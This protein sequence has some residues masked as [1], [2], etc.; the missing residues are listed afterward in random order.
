MN[1]GKTRMGV[2]LVLEQRCFCVNNSDFDFVSISLKA[3]SAVAECAL[4][5]GETFFGRSN[6]EKV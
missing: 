3:H 6:H 4:F 2:A 1:E 5:F